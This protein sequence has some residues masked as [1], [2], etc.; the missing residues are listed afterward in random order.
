MTQT[1]PWLIPSVLVAAWQLAAMPGLLSAQVL[2]APIEFVAA[3][4]N[5]AGSGAF[6][7][8]MEVSAWPAMPG[9]V[10]GGGISFTLGIGEEAKVFRVALGKSADS[11]ARSA[12][13]DA[14][15]WNPTYAKA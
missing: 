7:T 13:R 12:E 11:A 10:A 3:G 15:Q 2:P 1:L 9:F 4:R 14:L 8:D 5:L 6:W